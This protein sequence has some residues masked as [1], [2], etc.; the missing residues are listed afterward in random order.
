MDKEEAKKKFAAYLAGNSSPLPPEQRKL[1]TVGMTGG[2]FDVL[3]LGHMFTLQRAREN[4]D[5]LVAVI[6]SDEFV[7]KRKNKLIHP[8]EYRRQMVECIRFVDAAI[9][10]G[11]DRLE[12]LNKVKPDVIIFGYDQEP[13]I[14]DGYKIVKITE[15]MD[16]KLH[17]SSRIIQDLGY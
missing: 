4:C 3:H 9:S 8:Q 11:K 10:G 16:E 5:F 12:T 14:K 15:S 2:S 7:K 13:F 1:L 6:A 17:K